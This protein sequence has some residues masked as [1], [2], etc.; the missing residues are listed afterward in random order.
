MSLFLSLF[1]ARHAGLLYLVV[2]AIGWGL[3]WPA[4]KVL[5]GE[6]PPF[7]A[8]GTA[9]VTAALGLA[10]IARMSGERL[11]VPRRAVAP[12]VAAA[13]TNVFAW[14]GFS[15]L[16]LL[17]L[18]VQEAALL[19]FTM[20]IW[21]MLLAWPFRG[22]RPTARSLAALALGLAGLGVLFGGQEVGIGTDK[23]P[24]VLCALGAAILFALGTVSARAPLAIP[25]LAAVAWQVGI[26]CLPM[27]AAGLLFEKPDL[28]ALSPTGWALMAYMTV[29]PMALSYLCWFAALRRLPPATASIGTLLTPVIGVVTA[30]I[31]LGEPFGAKEILALC[32]T[33][34]GVALALRKT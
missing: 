17:W 2:A 1:R 11:A 6:W 32:L 18:K 4:M 3:N 21:A 15:T 33:L 13:M 27:V 30:A 14:M 16:S 24:G 10:L 29:V 34:G 25:P 19:V 5:L 22:E 31:T 8:R 20:P 28:D 26:G 23:L 9:G 7:F 12:L